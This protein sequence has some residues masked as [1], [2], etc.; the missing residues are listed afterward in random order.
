MPFAITFA[1]LLVTLG[2]P[3]S[4]LADITSKFPATN[5]NAE[6]GAPSLTI[7]TPGSVAAGDVLLAQI[8]FEKG[9][10]AAVAAPTGWTLER[11]TDSGSDLG[12]ALYSK[13]ATA[14]EPAAGY[15]WQFTK[16]GDDL[17]IRAAGGITP[18]AGVDVAAPLVASSG[19]WSLTAPAITAPAQSMLVGFF[20]VQKQTTLS[21]PAGMS[22]RYVHQHANGSGPT[23]M[24]TSEVLVSDGPTGDRTS[25]P[26]DG[27]EKA[28]AQLVALRADTDTGGGGDT[29]GGD[30]GGG[31]TGG[32]DTG[33]GDTGGGGDTTNPGDGGTD[34]S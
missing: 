31:D 21:V 10:D 12:Q 34:V 4:A 17:P 26:G 18:Y 14:F 28:V 20:G 16:D 6:G 3:A 7:D 33:G 8:S 5:A 15:T 30:T 9:T 32:G 25:T 19:A 2:A 1:S 13:V 11:R 22:D 24:S 27:G 23:I 29:G